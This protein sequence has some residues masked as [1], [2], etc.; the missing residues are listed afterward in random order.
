MKSPPIDGIHDGRRR[1]P[2]VTETERVTVLVQRYGLDIDSRQ[3]LVNGPWITRAVRSTIAKRVV[4]VHLVESAAEIAIAVDA[5]RHAV[6]VLRARVGG[7]RK[8]GRTALSSGG[9]SDG[10]KREVERS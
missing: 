7:R 2:E 4:V 5:R 3:R 1:W 8:R 10:P 9:C 6:V